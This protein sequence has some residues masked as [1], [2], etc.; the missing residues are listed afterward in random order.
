MR[1]KKGREEEWW[2][3]LSYTVYL[4][5]SRDSA[6]VTFCMPLQ[7]DSLQA[8]PLLPLQLHPS[9]LLVPSPGILLIYQDLALNAGASMSCGHIDNQPQ[10]YSLDSFLSKI[11]TDLDKLQEGKA[12]RETSFKFCR[13]VRLVPFSRV[14]LHWGIS[15][16]AFAHSFIQQ[17]LNKHLP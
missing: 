6:Q 2:V 16:F 14:F 17:T 9:S 8:S 3:I 5:Q 7:V 4:W 12:C 15:H 11:T 1:V 10:S 13:V